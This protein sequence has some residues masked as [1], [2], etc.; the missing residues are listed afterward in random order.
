[1]SGDLGIPIIEAK[2]I[3]LNKDWPT[4]KSKFKEFQSNQLFIG[5]GKN[6]YFAVL[7][8]SKPNARYAKDALDYQVIREDHKVNHCYKFNVGT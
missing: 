2:N 7:C 6:I 8:R 5:E 4:I 1:M 3:D